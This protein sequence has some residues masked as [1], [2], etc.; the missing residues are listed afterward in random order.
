MDTGFEGFAQN[1]EKLAQYCKERLNVELVILHDKFP[2]IIRD[3]KTPGTSSC[4]FCARMRRGALYTYISQHGFTKLALG[5]HAD[6][7]IESMLMSQLYNG[8]LWTQCP[9]APTKFEN[10]KVIRPLILVFE[11]QIKKYR[12]LMQFPVVTC[13]CEFEGDPNHKRAATK[14]MLIDM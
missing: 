12:D 13:N 11:E 6:D 2:E 8:C 5:H 9:L 4:S 3:H 7:A 1:C 14:R 10:I